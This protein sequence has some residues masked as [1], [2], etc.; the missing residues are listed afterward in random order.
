MS[1]NPSQEIRYERLKKAHDAGLT[2][3]TILLARRY[4]DRLS[5]SLAGLDLA[6]RI[7]D[8]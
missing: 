6:G 1:E 5:R 7:P 4:L 8:G 2:S 3:L